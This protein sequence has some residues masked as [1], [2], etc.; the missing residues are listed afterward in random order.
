VV[1]SSAGMCVAEC[2]EAGICIADA[3]DPFSCN[4]KCIHPNTKPAGKKK[5]YKNRIKVSLPNQV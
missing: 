1:K 5:P 4:C 3:K 2:A